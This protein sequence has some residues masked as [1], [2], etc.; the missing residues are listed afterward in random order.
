MN[1]IGREAADQTS[2]ET[3]VTD[4]VTGLPNRA[5]FEAVIDNEER[6]CRRYSGNPAVFVVELAADDAGRDDVVRQAASTL[7]TAIRDTDVLARVGPGAFALLAT[8]CDEDGMRFLAGRLKLWLE[9]AGIPAS[10]RARRR[11]SDLRQAWDEAYSGS[12]S[13]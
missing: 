5:G 4:R 10:V 11:V 2:G 13:G 9:I 3:V 6:R 8:H 12:G 7:A 1:E